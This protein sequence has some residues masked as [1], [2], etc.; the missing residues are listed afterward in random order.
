MLEKLI[1]HESGDHFPRSSGKE[2]ANHNV[3]LPQAR[4][5]A[6]TLDWRSGVQRHDEWKP[7]NRSVGRTWRQMRCNYIVLD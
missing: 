5:S 4:V 1:D 3:S 2:Q 7:Y 6:G